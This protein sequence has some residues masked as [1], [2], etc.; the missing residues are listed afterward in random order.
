MFF[1]KRNAEKA[2]FNGNWEEPGILGTRLEIEDGKLLVLWRNAPVLKTNFT[3]K[4]NDDGSYDAILEETGLRYEN[5][6]KDYATV[7]SLR[8]TG[9]ELC[10]EKHF[11]ITGPDSERLK[12]TENSRYGNYE[13]VDDEILPLLQGVWKGDNDYD[14]MKFKGNTLSLDET[15]SLRVRVLKSKSPSLNEYKIVNEDPSVDCVG[16]YYN[17]SF[18]GAEL[19][20]YVMVCDAPP[21]VIRFRKV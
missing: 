1:K 16:Y 8:L 5:S 13:I 17:V 11:P 2:L 9:E 18:N 3:V 10:F 6:G 7:T 12:R 21:H 19:T 4:K 14:V 20:A 15:R